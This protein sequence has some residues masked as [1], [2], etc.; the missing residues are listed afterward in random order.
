MRHA[1][2]LGDC[3]GH[4]CR[5]EYGAAVPEAA[6]PTHAFQSHS[7]RRGGARRRLQTGTHTPA[8]RGR[9]PVKCSRAGVGRVHIPTPSEAM[10]FTWAANG[11]TASTHIVCVS[12]HDV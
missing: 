3:S 4:E 2:A 12:R 5:Q 6:V 8:M 7:P 10:L 1:V 11:A 9:A